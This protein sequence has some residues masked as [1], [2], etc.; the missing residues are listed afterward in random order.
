M[1]VTTFI[2]EDAIYG[3][4]AAIHHINS[5][6]LLARASLK[7]ATVVR[8]RGF[9]ATSICFI[10]SSGDLQTVSGKKCSYVCYVGY[11]E[12]VWGCRS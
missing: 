6:P 3:W 7:R 12:L 4:H 2:F 11:D 9:K 8:L 10:V 5:P 1:S